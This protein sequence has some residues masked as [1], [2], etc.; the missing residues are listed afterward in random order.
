MTGFGEWGYALAFYKKAHKGDR[1]YQ[2]W[3][4]GCHP[5]SIQDDVMMRQK[6][7]Y[8]HPLLSR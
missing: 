6:I 2:F 3:Q 8:I 4:E 1:E 7:E 5:E